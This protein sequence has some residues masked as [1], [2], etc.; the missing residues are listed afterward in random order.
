MNLQI[1]P[2]IE[3]LTG[4]TGLAIID[5]I[6]EGERDPAQLAK[7][8]DPRITA[9]PEIIQKSLVG[10]WQPPPLFT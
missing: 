1:Q 10:H 9:K 6:L 4:V 8:R 7:L 2:V 3:D 5:A